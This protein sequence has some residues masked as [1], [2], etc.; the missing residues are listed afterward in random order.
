MKKQFGGFR[1]K[2]NRTYDEKLEQEARIERFKRSRGHERKPD[3]VVETYF[4]TA[5]GEPLTVG[6]YGTDQILTDMGQVNRVF[7]EHNF[8]IEYDLIEAYEYAGAVEL[9]PSSQH[10]HMAL[11]VLFGNNDKHLKQRLEAGKH[12]QLVLTTSKEGLETDT[13]KLAELMRD[14]IDALRAK[15]SGDENALKNMSRER[16]NKRWGFGK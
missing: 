7:Q 11:D 4:R 5:A 13:E 2:S 14:A 1:D 12:V 3:L 6:Y 10:A 8:I 16:T 9:F 15:A